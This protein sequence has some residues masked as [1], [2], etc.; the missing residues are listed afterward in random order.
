MTGIDLHIQFRVKF[1]DLNTNKNKNLLPEEINIIL[2]DQLETVITTICNKESNKRGEGYGDSRLR[3]DMIQNHLK[4][5]STI[6][7]E[8]GTLTLSSFNKGKYTNLPIDYFMATGIEC[9][10]KDNCTVNYRKPAREYP[11]GRDLR[12]A[13]NNYYYKSSTL[14]PIVEVRNNKI[15]AYENDFTIT[16]IFI[17]Y[18]KSLPIIKYSDT[19]LP[20]SDDLWRIVI[21]NAVTKSLAISNRDYNALKV[22]TQITE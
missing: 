5:E 1:N 3:V 13:L 2:K 22:E 14:S 18:C 15:Y 21:D 4:D 12:N 6:S 8:S 11:N 7:T 17:S 16:G 20:F 19:I 9:S 10:S